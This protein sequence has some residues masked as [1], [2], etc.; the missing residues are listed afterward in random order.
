MAQDALTALHLT[1][2]NLVLLTQHLRD[3]QSSSRQSPVLGK[4]GLLPARDEVQRTF[5]LGNW[6]PVQWGQGCSHRDAALSLLGYNIML[7][8][9]HHL[10]SVHDEEAGM[11]KAC[12]HPPAWFGPQEGLETAPH[13]L[14]RSQVLPRLPEL[15]MPTTGSP[16]RAIT[17][18][19]SRPPRSQP[20]LIR[21]LWGAANTGAE[22]LPEMLELQKMQK[23]RCWSCKRWRPRCWR[24][25]RCKD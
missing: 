24:C 16:G 21:D 4:R 25:R 23:Q 6:P 5:P 22:M 15:P 7:K 3:A 20:S 9:Q 13:A 19:R 17:P 12:Q 11:S 18:G 2:T 14:V 8:A 1:A 10:F